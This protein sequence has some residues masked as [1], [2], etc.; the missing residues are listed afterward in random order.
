MKKGTV[1][2]LF[3]MTCQF[4]HAGFEFGYGY[5][6][7]NPKELNRVLYGY[8]L[9]NA[10]ILTKQMP[11]FHYTQGLSVGFKIPSAKYAGY[12]IRWVNRHGSISAQGTD[13]SG[14][15]IIR[16]LKFRTNC[17]N[18]GGYAGNKSHSFGFSMDF[19]VNFKGWTRRYASTDTKPE[20]EKIFPV[21]PNPLAIFSYIIPTAITVHYQYNIGPVGVRLF[22]QYQ[23]FRMNMEK[24]EPTLLGTYMRDGGL[25]ALSV[26]DCYS[27]VGVE[28]NL[29]IG[30]R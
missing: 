28:L 5:A 1:L 17:L 8:N 29:T 26:K 11:M 19:G 3:L 6:Y 15:T 7:G 25:L 16:D 14:A 23:Y 9:R 27:N 20:W 30:K 22:Y 18:V 13:A 10:S 24:L 21:E 12:E 4:A 2:I